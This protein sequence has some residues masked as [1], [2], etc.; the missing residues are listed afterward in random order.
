MSSRRAAMERQLQLLKGAKAVA[1]CTPDAKVTKHK[2]DAKYRRWA[3][4]LKA[5]RYLLRKKELI[6]LAVRGRGVHRSLRMEEVS[7]TR[8]DVVW[9]Q[10]VLLASAL[11]IACAAK[12]RDPSHFSLQGLPKGVKDDGKEKDDSREKRTRRIRAVQRRRTRRART[13]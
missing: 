11:R 12:W 5:G 8:V 4:Y 10:P 9:A 3:F 13:P 2:L 1:K 6:G 7:D